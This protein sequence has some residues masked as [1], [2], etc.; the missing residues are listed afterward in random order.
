MIFIWILIAVSFVQ[1]QQDR[2]P[3]NPLLIELSGRLKSI[4]QAVQVAV[5]NGDRDKCESALFKLQYL[6]FELGAFESTVSN[7]NDE[8]MQLEIASNISCIQRYANSFLGIVNDFWDEKKGRWTKLVCRQV[9]PS[10]SLLVKS[11]N[12]SRTATIA[13]LRSIGDAIQEAVQ[14]NDLAAIKSEVEMFSQ[15]WKRV[16]NMTQ[17]MLNWDPNPAQVQQQKRL[18]NYA[19]RVLFDAE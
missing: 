15:T 13:Q 14:S 4:E 3:A 11:L 17:E 10:L 19:A 8:L 12:D 5:S 1:A 2:S 7:I 6:A 18:A 9:V 16:A